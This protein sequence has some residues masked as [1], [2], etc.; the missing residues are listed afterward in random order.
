MITTAYGLE[1]GEQ[2]QLQADPQ[3]QKAL[4][5]QPQA[6]QLAENVSLEKSTSVPH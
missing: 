6:R 3:L 1:A 5:S 2:I 4:E